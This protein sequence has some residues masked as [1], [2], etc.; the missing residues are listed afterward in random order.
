MCGSWNGKKIKLIFFEVA[1]SI[2][3][4][5]VHNRT[6]WRKVK[7]SDPILMLDS[8]EVSLYFIVAYACTHASTQN[9]LNKIASDTFIE[10][11]DTFVSSEEEKNNLWK[12]R[13]VSG[14][15]TL[16]VNVQCNIVP[17]SMRIERGKMSVI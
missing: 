2:T 9:E 1:H 3:N 12:V 10:N 5:I 4:I 6:M 15:A 8:Y 11:C 13:M 7:I 17:K 14:A 16:S